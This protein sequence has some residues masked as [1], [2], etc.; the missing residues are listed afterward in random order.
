MALEVVHPFTMEAPLDSILLTN[1]KAIC[2]DPQGVI[3]SRADLL[4][5]FSARAT[6]LMQMLL[7][8]L[9]SV[10]DPHLRRLLRGVEDD[11]I[12]ALGQFFHVALW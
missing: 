9:K 1:I 3:K 7:N 5:Q 11:Q 2:Q 8:E 6:A 12:P 4:S 10:R